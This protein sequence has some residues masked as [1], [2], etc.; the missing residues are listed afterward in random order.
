[1]RRADRGHQ[2]EPVSDAASSTLTAQV[3]ERLR[4]DIILVALQPG[5]KLTLDLLK[6]RYSVGMTPLREALYRLS[7]SML[8]VLEDRRGFRVAPV[9]PSHL[10]EVI[11]SREEV[12]ALLLRNSL[13]HGDVDWEARIVAAYHGLMRAS[14]YRPNPGPYTVEWEG[15]HRTFHDAI[16]SAARLPMLEDFHRSLWD[17]CARY[18]NLAY[19]GKPIETAVFDGH[20]QIMD[21]VLARDEQL[22]DVLLRRHIRLATA[23]IMES[24]F[25]DVPGAA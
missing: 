6:E 2:D 24:V 10:A 11:A 15:A 5:Q 8:V 3:Y 4:D 19:G 16:L 14:E 9:S 17:H 21:A 18:R 12:E 1:M 25:P 13:Q 22:A 23:H 20:Q 7:A